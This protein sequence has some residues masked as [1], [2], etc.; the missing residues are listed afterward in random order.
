[1]SYFW[2]MPQISPLEFDGRCYDE[3]FDPAFHWELTCHMDIP[4]SYEN[5]KAVREA[6][7]EAFEAYATGQFE[8]AGFQSEKAA[9]AMLHRVSKDAEQLMSSLGS[10]YE[11]EETQSKLVR[12]IRS[13]KTK[14]IRSDGLKLAATL[15]EE[16]RDNPLFSLRQLLSD[17]YISA[18]RARNRKPQKPA[19]HYAPK[20]H[21][22]GEPD[23]D[24][25][26]QAVR[27]RKWDATDSFENDMRRWK[28]R[29]QA[30]K[31]PKDH[32]LQCFLRKF[33][34]AWTSLSPHPF[35][36]GHNYGGIIQ[37][38]SRTVDAVELSFSQHDHKFTRQNIVTAIRKINVETSV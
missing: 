18:E 33:Q 4:C 2:P 17:L 24:K 22:N 14:Y 10:L 15:D 28:T 13:N 12:E 36:H 11:F 23:M 19:F 29:S 6:H 37:N 26:E 3:I 31:V 21:P 34:S 5:L 25:L 32:A 9:N 35:T 27:D 7:Y 16:S 30:H 38:V 20:T 8:R 1:M